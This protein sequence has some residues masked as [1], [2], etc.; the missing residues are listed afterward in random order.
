MR[1]S[2]SETEAV[3]V[4]SSLAFFAESRYHSI[5]PDVINHIAFDVSMNLTQNFKRVAV[6]NGA[7]DPRPFDLKEYLSQMLLGLRL[8]HVSGRKNEVSC[9]RF[10]DDRVFSPKN[11]V[12]IWIF[13]PLIAVGVAYDVILSIT[14]LRKNFL[15]VH[16]LKVKRGKAQ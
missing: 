6:D 3:K 4:I 8:H 14:R 5:S 10:D 9:I 1:A 13:S 2:N 12:R 7:S 15:A 11:L 16:E